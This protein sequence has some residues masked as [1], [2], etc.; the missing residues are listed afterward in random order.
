MNRNFIV[1][2]LLGLFGYLAWR[3]FGKKD[4]LQAHM[5]EEKSLQTI[6]E[7][8]VQVDTA[9]LNMYPLTTI[10]DTPLAGIHYD[11]FDVDGRGS[12]PKP[13]DMFT[14]TPGNQ[15]LLHKIGFPERISEN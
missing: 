1:I 7:G 4:Y 9:A 14:S 3:H 13:I 8:I 2:A 15:A 10:G 11:P 6:G 12:D 5:L